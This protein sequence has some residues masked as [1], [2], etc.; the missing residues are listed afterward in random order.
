MTQVQS[1]LI[2]IIFMIATITTSYLILDRADKTGLTVEQAARTAFGTLGKAGTDLSSLS[3][4]M[5][6]FSATVAKSTQQGMDWVKILLIILVGI[7]AVALVLDRL[8]S[9]R[10]S[11]N[12]GSLVELI[13]RSKTSQR[14]RATTTSIRKNLS[15]GLHLFTLLLQSITAKIIYTIILTFFSMLI[16]SQPVNNP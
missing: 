7:L 8:D 16:S 12:I 15:S 14:A 13:K 5:Q 9:R 3:A 11:H 10:D 2:I 4:N 1:W 6:I